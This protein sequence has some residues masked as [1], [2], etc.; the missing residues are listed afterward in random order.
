MNFWRILTRQTKA[1]REQRKFF[2]LLKFARQ[3]AEE[4]PL[5]L[6]DVVRLYLRPLQTE[7]LL[8][9][10]ESEMHGARGEIEIRSFFIPSGPAGLRDYWNY[11]RCDPQNF[12]VNLARDP[13]MPCPWHRHRYVD[14]LAHIGQNKKCGQWQEDINHRVV[15]LLPWGIAFVIGGNHSI[16][17]GV[18]SAEGSITPVEVYEMGNLLDAVECDGRNFLSTGTKEP[19]CG[20]RDYRIAALFEV[21]RLMRAHEVVPMRVVL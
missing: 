16:A 19:I 17:S 14:A 3:V 5:A 13:V 11:Q 4:N 1:S 7:L 6:V 18:M 8:S 12:T 10:A 9:C 15:V 20:V 21:G 2:N